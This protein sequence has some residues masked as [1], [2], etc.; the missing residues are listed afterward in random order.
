MYVCGPT[1]YD[2]PHLG[3]ARSVVVFDQLYRVLTRLYG[4]VKYVRNITDIDDKI[5]EAAELNGETIEFLTAR[6]IEFFHADMAALNALPPVIEPRATTHIPHMINFISRLMAL[7]YAYEAEGH[8]LYSVQR[9]ADY[10]RLSGRTHGGLPGG[11]NM[12]WGGYKEDMKDFVLWKPSE[13]DQP[14]W[15]SPWSRGR[16]GWHIECSA[17]CEAHLGDH[18]DIHGGGIDLVFPHHENEIAQSE[19][20]HAERLANFWVHNE[21]LT[22]DGQ[23]MSKSAGNFITVPEVLKDQPGEVV[24]LA[25]LMTHYQNPLDWTTSRVDFARRLLNRLYRALNLRTPPGEVDEK[26]LNALSNNLNTS[27]A[28]LILD[29]MI[30]RALSHDPADLKESAQFLGL[31]MMNP[32]EW[33][34]RTSVDKLEID[35]LIDERNQAR[36]EKDYKKADEIRKGLANRGIILEDVDGTTTWRTETS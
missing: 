21:F 6:T 10:G 36:A 34:Q 16:P 29:S 35:R 28:V 3:N 23:K 25:L 5:M 13:D 33:F 2:R 27:S 22:V 11:P 32:E 8:V 24:R 1:V 18:I 26:I 30:T 20:V 7:G 9:W 17:M 19:A 12:T 14:G 15:D 4:E 31:G